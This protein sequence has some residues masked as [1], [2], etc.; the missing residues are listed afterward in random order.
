VLLAWTLVYV[1]TVVVVMARR[2]A[3]DPTLRGTASVLLVRPCAGAPELAARSLPS[4]PREAT[5]RLRW[6]AAVD[7]PDDPAWAP[8]LAARDQLVADGIDAH[9]LATAAT[10]PNHKVGQLAAAI[11]R[12]GD[13]RDIVVVADADVDLGAAR[14]GAVIAP[15][16]GPAPAAACWSA[17]VEADGDGLGDRVSA[18]ILSASLQS[19]VLLSALD[20]RL[21]VGKLFAVRLDALTA[22]GGMAALGAHLGEDFELARRLR[23][24]G[25]EIVVTRAAARSLTRGR[26]LASV[27]DRYTRWLTVVRMQRPLALLGYPF[28][29]AAAPGLLALAAVVYVDAPALASACAIAVV[30]A[31]LAVVAIGRH[32]SGL[33]LRA[34]GFTLAVPVD[35]F[36]LVALARCLL[37]RRIRWADRTLRFGDDGRL[38]RAP[39]AGDP[40]AREAVEHAGGEPMTTRGG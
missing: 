21:F 1:A 10:T 33:P 32:R 37:A 16:T 14:L 9:V 24:H 12:L 29:L 18:A 35:V 25:G 20:R 26:S 2:R 11:E 30:L 40:P 31:R 15:L 19:F 38:E 3:P 34:V 4:L 27:L 28:L 6:V 8:A 7:G 5:T 23:E 13:G 39:E 17:P 22:V 36:L